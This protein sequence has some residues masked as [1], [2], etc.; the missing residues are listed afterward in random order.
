MELE[1]DLLIVPHEFCLLAYTDSGCDIF[2]DRL[3]IGS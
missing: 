1:I 2:R 3:G